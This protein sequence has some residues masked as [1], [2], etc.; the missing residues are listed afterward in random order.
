[1]HALLFF[2][3]F[4]IVH[5]LC[6]FVAFVLGCRGRAA[7]GPRVS[8]LRTNGV[9]TNGA[10]AKVMNFVRLGKQIRP[11]TFWEDK[12]RLTGVPKKSL[13]RK[14][15]KFAA[16][17]LVLNPIVPLP[18]TCC[19]CKGRCQTQQG[20]AQRCPGGRAKLKPFKN[21]L[22]RSGAIN[23]CRGVRNYIIRSI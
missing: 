2:T 7:R 17:P 4:V 20:R 15:M 14:N 21:A 3:R 18:R 19:V 1:M 16:A 23:Q 6:C 12:S 22:S 9:N 5:Y 11:V 10:A 13:R 8:W